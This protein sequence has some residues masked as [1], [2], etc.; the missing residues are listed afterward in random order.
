MGPRREVVSRKESEVIA[1]IIAA[2][3]AGIFGFGSS[4]LIGAWVER[5]EQR[6]HDRLMA[7][8]TAVMAEGNRRLHLEEKE[9]EE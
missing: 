6:Q 5:A 7:A 8:M 1:T 2:I 9:W 4:W 3:A